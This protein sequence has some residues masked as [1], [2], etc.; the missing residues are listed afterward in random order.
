MASWPHLFSQRPNFLIPSRWGLGS[1][2][3]NLVVTQTFG[4]KKSSSTKSVSTFRVL[5][6]CVASAQSLCRVDTKIRPNLKELAGQGFKS[7]ASETIICKK[8]QG[9]PTGLETMGGHYKPFSLHR[10]LHWSQPP[11]LAPIAL[12]WPMG[13]FFP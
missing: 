6:F 8:I 1:Q 11:N 7:T 5:A 12:S 4:P 3:M 13:P 2:H 10:S 9:H